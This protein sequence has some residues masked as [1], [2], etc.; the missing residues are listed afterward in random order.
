MLQKSETSLFGFKPGII[1]V[2]TMN[3]L[4]TVLKNISG[5]KIFFCFPTGFFA[6]IVIGFQHK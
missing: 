5:F 2:N 6:S 3:S 1:S 4:D